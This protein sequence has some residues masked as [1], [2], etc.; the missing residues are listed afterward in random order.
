MER[1]MKDKVK[2]ALQATLVYFMLYG[3]TALVSYGVIVMGV[4]LHGILT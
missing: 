4:Y 3:F 1:R 2:R